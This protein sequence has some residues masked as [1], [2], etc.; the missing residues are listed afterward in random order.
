MLPVAVYHPQM[1]SETSSTDKRHLCATVSSLSSEGICPLRSLYNCFNT[2]EGGSV[3]SERESSVFFLAWGSG[4]YKT[5]YNCYPWVWRVRN[6]NW[7]GSDG[8]PVVWGYVYISPRNFEIVSDANAHY[9]WLALT[10]TISGMRRERNRGG[11]CLLCLMLVTA[12]WCSQIL[13]F[14]HINT[15]VIYGR[16]YTEVLVIYGTSQEWKDW[17]DLKRDRK[18]LIKWASVSLPVSLPRAL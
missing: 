17:S 9:T 5:Q 18:I 8:W 2:D 14:V 3:S 1:Q 10:V 13:N 15:K 6:R 12:L 4:Q 11:R 16:L 7:N